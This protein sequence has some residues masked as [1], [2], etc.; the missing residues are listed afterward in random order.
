[1]KVI[2]FVSSSGY[3]TISNNDNGGTGVSFNYSEWNN[4]RQY[5]ISKFT[6]SLQREMETGNIADLMAYNEISKVQVAS[7]MPGARVVGME[8]KL[9]EIRRLNQLKESAL[10]PSKNLG[11][12]KLL[13]YDIVNAG[14][15]KTY[16]GS[17]NENTRRLYRLKIEYGYRFIDPK[18]DYHH[19]MHDLALELMDNARKNMMHLGDLDRKWFNDRI[20][21]NDL[22][23]ELLSPYR[24]GADYD[25]RKTDLRDNS[26]KYR[27]GLGTKLLTAIL[28][29]PGGLILGPRISIVST[30]PMDEDRVKN[31]MAILDNTG[32]FTELRKL[33][34]N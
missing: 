14:F 25:Y 12:F 6:N 24:W 7:E 16:D 11:P 27:K 26:V 3:N 32:Q 33:E 15:I 22:Q 20:Y 8:D 13:R 30:K 23:M 17:G 5:N 21:A 10:E 1:M 4:T 19:K 34:N 18:P 2:G 29:V 9:T 31:L 28:G